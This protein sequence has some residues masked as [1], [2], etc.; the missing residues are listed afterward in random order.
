MHLC[1]DR[2]SIAVVIS[3]LPPITGRPS[4]CNTYTTSSSPVIS[5]GWGY[6]RFCTSGNRE[7]RERSESARRKRKER[8]REQIQ[9]TF[10][11]DLFIVAARISVRI[12]Q[13][14]ACFKAHKYDFLNRKRQK[15][16][17]MWYKP[18]C[19]FAFKFCSTV[20][21]C[22]RIYQLNYES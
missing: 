19:T 10:G 15:C 11:R 5:S 8:I 17:T 21:A 1:A 18:L 9:E 2:F 22:Q 20:L 7:N 13:C 4:V 6:G 12:Q 16:S 3:K 14:C